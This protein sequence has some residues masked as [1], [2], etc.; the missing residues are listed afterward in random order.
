MD[1][2]LIYPMF[3]LVIF[4]FL[5]GLCVGGSR[6]ISVRKERVDPKYLQLMSGGTAPDY[7]V[8]F[9]RNFS[10]LF[11]VPILFYVAS[12]LI[13]AL[14]LSNHYLVY[15][16]WSF[17]A[18]RVVHTII[19]V[20]YNKPIHRFLAFLLSTVIAILMWLELVLIVSQ[21]SP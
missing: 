12:T 2:D 15:L 8:K 3:S 21:A 14:G 5:V 16:A 18:L 13:I 20:T 1:L 17:V 6:I 7:M 4:T 19:H 9:S 11:E 10:N